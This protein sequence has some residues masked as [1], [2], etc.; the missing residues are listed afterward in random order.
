MQPTAMGSERN[1]LANSQHTVAWMAMQR[2]TNASITFTSPRVGG[3]AQGQ[4]APKRLKFLE[5][6]TSDFE[7]LATNHPGPGISVE[8][9]KC[10]QDHL[11]NRADIRKVNAAVIGHADVVTTPWLDFHYVHPDNVS[12]Y[13]L[14]WW[15]KGCSGVG[16]VSWATV[17]GAN[18][19]YASMLRM[20]LKHL[21]EMVRVPTTSYPL[22]VEGVETIDYLKLDMEGTEPPVLVD[23]IALCEQR[24]LCP[25]KL[26]FEAKFHR[27]RPPPP[28]R[29]GVEKDRLDTERALLRAAGF[30][31]KVPCGVLDCDCWYKGGREAVASRPLLR[32]RSGRII[33]AH[34]QR[35]EPHM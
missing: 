26:T 14:P 21:V 3:T 17:K 20:K 35:P 5:V 11:P 7:A 22:L 30:H 9:M 10:Y 33:T 32:S 27:N 19:C 4:E 8:A 24:Q 25:K 34:D 28:G 29:P 1:E 15:V 13:Q 23:V 6:G 31:C 18:D 16:P 12:A 2:A